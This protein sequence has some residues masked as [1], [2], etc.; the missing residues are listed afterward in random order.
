MFDSLYR[1]RVLT[2]EK[3]LKLPGLTEGIKREFVEISADI[4]SPRID[5]LLQH[6]AR[7]QG[8]RAISLIKTPNSCSI[9]LVH[10]SAF[11]LDCSHRLCKACIDKCST[12]LEPHRY[13][14][15]T[16]LLCQRGNRSTFV[17]KP[18]TA[19]VRKIELGGVAPGQTLVFLKE[20]RRSL[21]LTSIPIWELFD[22]VIASGTG[23]CDLYL[24]LEIVANKDRNV[25]CSRN[26]YRGMGTG[27]LRIP[28]LETWKP[29]DCRKQR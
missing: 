2:C 28:Y 23:I 11:T 10:T 21:D 13:R 4:Q 20:L 5:S 14:P 22:T 25:F 16:C 17:L 26:I 8:D 7:V 19:G 27:R 29:E 24:T 3:Q 6:L 1:E 15:T 9:C 12:E 18:P